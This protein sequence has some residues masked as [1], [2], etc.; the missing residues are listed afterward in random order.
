MLVVGAFCLGA[1]WS[2]LHP[3][4]P[5]ECRAAAVRF[6]TFWTVKVSNHDCVILSTIRYNPSNHDCVILSTIQYNPSNHDCLILSTIWY[7][8]SNHVFVILSTS[9]YNP[10]FS[11]LFAKLVEL[12]F[13]R[14]EKIATYRLLY[15]QFVVHGRRGVGYC[16]LGW[17]S[18][19]QRT[20]A[21]TES[22]PKAL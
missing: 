10:S 20:L 18:N 9:C 4:L 13:Y 19:F 6:I 22:M 16:L 12:W 21:T 5:W 17:E 11:C 14:L 7:N 1:S 8:P 15:I 3:I 2:F